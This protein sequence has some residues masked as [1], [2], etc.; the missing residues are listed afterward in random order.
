MLILAG[1][2]AM[3][4]LYQSS[5]NGAGP[6]ELDVRVD[7]QRWAPLVVE[8]TRRAQALLQG[9]M[10]EYDLNCRTT[11]A[12]LEAAPGFREPIADEREPTVDADAA[13]SDLDEQRARRAE[14]EEES[15]RRDGIS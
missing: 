1:S 6:V 3:H 8:H 11:A 12:G 4:A 15:Y 2:G 7:W 14:L 10:E 13:W 5:A 9:W